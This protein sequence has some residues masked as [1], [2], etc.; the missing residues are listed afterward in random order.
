VQGAAVYIDVAQ[1]GAV[2]CINSGDQI[3]RWNGHGWDAMPGA[4][5]TV[6]VGSARDGM[7]EWDE[8]I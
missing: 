2:W 6:G 4:A 5:K 3:F 8:S 1:D 7:L